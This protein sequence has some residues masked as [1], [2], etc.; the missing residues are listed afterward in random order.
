MGAVFRMLEQMNARRRAIRISLWGRRASESGP[1][2]RWFAAVLSSYILLSGS[3]CAVPW[4]PTAPVERVFVYRDVDGY[5]I[6]SPCELGIMTAKVLQP[7]RDDPH[8]YSWVA[9]AKSESTT[10][11][12]PF[13]PSLSNYSVVTSGELIADEPSVIVAMHSRG[14]EWEAAA[15]MVTFG[16]LA[17]GDVAYQ[18]GVVK[19]EDWDRLE[20]KLFS[21]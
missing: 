9:N 15:I 4:A 20:P 16:S 21:C 10:S 3:G 18:G 19:Q 14:N 6:A 8:T 12:I 2:W 13:A 17:L 1:R 11:R 7:A 5:W